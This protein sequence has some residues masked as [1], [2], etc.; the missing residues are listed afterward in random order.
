MTNSS[1]Q[2][3]I[4]ARICYC[5]KLLLV[6]PAQPRWKVVTGTVVANIVATDGPLHKDLGVG[7]SCSPW[8]HKGGAFGSCLAFPSQPSKKQ[9]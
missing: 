2:R 7:I 8:H 3:C 9:K 4:L 1:H 6:D 5:W